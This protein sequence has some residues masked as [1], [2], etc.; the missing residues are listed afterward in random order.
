[1]TRIVPPISSENDPNT[2][3]KNAQV[4]PLE[5]SMLEAKLRKERELQLRKEKNAQL[6][7]DVKRTKK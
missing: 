6:V 5:K 3:P 7:A 4:D 2:D 1:M